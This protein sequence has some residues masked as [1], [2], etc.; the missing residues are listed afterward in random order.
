MRKTLDSMTLHDGLNGVYELSDNLCNGENMYVKSENHNTVFWRCR[1]NGKMSWCIGPRANSQEKSNK[2]WAHLS[3]ELFTPSQSCNAIW[4][5][6]CY[7]TLSWIFQP[8]VDITQQ[9]EDSECSV[10]SCCI[11]LTTRSSH[12]SIPCGH[13]CVCKYCAEKCSFNLTTCPICRKRSYRFLRIF[14]WLDL[15]A[16]RMAFAQGL[17][18]ARSKACAGSFCS[19]THT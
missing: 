3:A 15:L 4:R 1:V 5:V 10:Q 2:I 13:M 16:F 8:N 9:T 18:V 6:Y 7:N 19:C 14:L 17:N 12:A 11:C